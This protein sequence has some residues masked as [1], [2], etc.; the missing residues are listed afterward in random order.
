MNKKSTKKRKKKGGKKNPRVAWLI[1]AAGGAL[2]VVVLLGVVWST[3]G[4]AFFGKV[5][6]ALGGGGESRMERYAEAPPEA[7]ADLLYLSY[8]DSLA[9]DD[10]ALPREK[11]GVTRENVV[12]LV[13]EQAGV[14]REVMEEWG[15]LPEAEEGHGELNGIFREMYRRE[16]VALPI[17]DASLWKHVREKKVNTGHILFGQTGWASGGQIDFCGVVTAANWLQPEYTAVLYREPHTGQLV[18]GSVK[19]MPTIAYY[20]SGRP[21]DNLRAV[22][23]QYF[24][25]GLENLKGRKPLFKGPR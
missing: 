22:Y 6:D 14:S 7:R 4:G 18:H 20:G 21:G 11:G 10:R 15:L 16:R 24:R 8:L 1:V 25:L 13:A 3:S 9:R 5:G 2:S 17:E 23:E 12:R 19:E